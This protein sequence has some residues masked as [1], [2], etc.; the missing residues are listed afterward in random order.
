M[1]KYQVDVKA[2]LEQTVLSALSI[3]QN[4]IKI[5]LVKVINCTNNIQ[6]IS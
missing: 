6:P 5:H 3:Y 1:W 4:V 2:E